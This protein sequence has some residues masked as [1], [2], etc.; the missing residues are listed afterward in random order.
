MEQKDFIGQLE[1]SREGSERLDSKRRRIR[2]P[3][4]FNGPFE[5]LAFPNM[6]QTNIS[7]QDRAFGKLIIDGVVANG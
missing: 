3:Y 4:E 5:R 1:G 2:Q 6:Q 7:F